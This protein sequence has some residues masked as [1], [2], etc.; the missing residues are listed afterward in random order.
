MFILVLWSTSSVDP[1]FARHIKILRITL[2][3]VIPPQ[4]HV[5]MK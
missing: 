3:H 2:N 4:A 1:E 5:S